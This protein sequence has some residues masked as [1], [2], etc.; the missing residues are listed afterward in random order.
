MAL[1]FAPG[2]EGAGGAFGGAGRADVAAVEEEPVMGQGTVGGRDVA[3]EVLLDGVRRGAAGE[4]QAVRNP[5]YVRVHRYHGLVVK[6]ARDYVRGLASRSGK[7][8]EAVDLRGDFAAEV[9][10]HLAGHGDEVPGLVV[11]V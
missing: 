6:D 8:H 4:A 10:H 11:G 5:E 3:L 2:G 7:G 9:A 1:G